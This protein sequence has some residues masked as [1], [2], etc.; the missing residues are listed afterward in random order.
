MLP[1]I[2]KVFS[3]SASAISGPIELQYIAFESNKNIRERT[4]DIL[5]KKLG[6]V[7]VPSDVDLT[8]ATAGTIR[9]DIRSFRGIVTTEKDDKDNHDNQPNLWS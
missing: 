3:E 9:A 6:F 5:S 4:I 1:Y 7:S 2:Q 8:A